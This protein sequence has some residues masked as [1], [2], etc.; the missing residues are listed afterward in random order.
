MEAARQA[1]YNELADVIEFD[2]TYLNFHHMALL[3]DRMTSNHNL[4]AIFR[5]GIL[6][7]NIGPISKSTFEVHTEVLLDAAR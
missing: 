2:G 1:I 3:C 4:V 5:S 7:D 6:T